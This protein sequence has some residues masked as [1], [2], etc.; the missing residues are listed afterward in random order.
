MIYESIEAGLLAGPLLKDLHLSRLE[1]DPRVRDAAGML[2]ANERKLLVALT[3]D[4]YRG[5][6][7]VIDGGSF[8][9]SSTVA[10]AAGLKRNPGHA[11]LE[12]MAF[13]GA[14]PIHAY[15]LGVLPAPKGAKA[16]PVR[17][18]GDIEY[19]MGDSFLPILESNIAPDRELIDL[20]IGDL[21]DYVWDGSPI[22]ICFIDVCKTIRLNAHVSAQFY[23]A[24]IPGASMLINQDFFFDRLP[25]IKV[26]MGY[27]ADYF[28]WEGQV[29]TSSV[30]STVKAVPDDI[31]RYDPFREGTLEDC[32][33]YHDAVAFTG[34][35]RKYAY[36]LDVSR[37]YLMAL[38]GRSDMALEH[39]RAV[40]ETYEDLL[41]DEETDRGNRFRMD[42]AVRQISNGNIFKVS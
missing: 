25:W 1:L 42:R 33:A 26:T 8:F 38:K 5:S 20:H 19:R 11:S 10:L 6:G 15:E 31:A 32:L 35:E 12:M 17:R 13:P 22:E 24:L 16:P 30:Y 28:R 7:A 34:L 9:G 23:P 27:L 2:S 14:K 36:Y 3:R 40:E 37:G 21:N 29:F 39:L 18:F 41:A 4:R